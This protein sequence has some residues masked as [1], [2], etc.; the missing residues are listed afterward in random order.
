MYSILLAVD[1]DRET[2]N[3]LVNDIEQL[4]DA[5]DRCEITL[6]HVFRNAQISQRVSIHQLA[7]GYD[8]E[9]FEHQ[10]PVSV[11]ETA[12][13]LEAS[14]A[15]VELELASGEPSSEITRIAR[16]RDVD[17]IHIGGKNTSP[18]GKAIFG[19]VTQSVIFGTDVP[20]TVCGK[21]K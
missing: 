7:S 21:S 6:V 2:A 19:S 3:H 12:E 18:A 14:A 16:A 13:A 20:V 15:T 4:I 8:D 17:N 5:V 11:Q 1:D 10:I 9:E